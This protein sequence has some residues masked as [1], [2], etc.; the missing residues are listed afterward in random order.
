MYCTATMDNLAKLVYR[1]QRIV[2]MY[3]GEPL[4]PP[5]EMIHDVHTISKCSPTSIAMN[6]TA[7]AFIENKK[8]MLPHKS[9]EPCKV[10]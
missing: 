9:R 1:D 4:V 8:L 7:N 2:F 10:W 5:L 6:A 3:K